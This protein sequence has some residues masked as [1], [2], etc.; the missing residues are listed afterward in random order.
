MFSSSQ[1]LELVSALMN[2][3]A[4]AVAQPQPSEPSRNAVSSTNSL[5]QATMSA[6]SSSSSS[7]PSSSSASSSCAHSTAALS[8]RPSTLPDIS[9]P[10][11]LPRSSLSSSSNAPAKEQS[12]QKSSSAAP[13]S[14][15]DPTSGTV[16]TDTAATVSTGTA[17]TA[18]KVPSTSVP[19]V[20]TSSVP[21]VY[22]YPHSGSLPRPLVHPVSSN[23]MQPLPISS[24]SP[25][26]SSVPSYPM[27]NPTAYPSNPALP[28]TLLP[29]I[30]TMPQPAPPSQLAPAVHMHPIRQHTSQMPLSQPLPHFYY[31]PSARPLS[32]TSVNADIH[33]PPMYYPVQPT[34]APSKLPTLS[35]NAT[36]LPQASTVQPQ[37]QDSTGQSDH[38]IKEQQQSQPVEDK[39]STSAPRPYSGADRTEALRRYKEKKSRRKSAAVSIRY[40]IRKQLADSRPRFRGRFYKPPHGRV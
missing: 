3:R 15:A 26:M 12:L 22:S 35:P 19:Y 13:V 10:P 2:M 5:P 23:A 7:S 25:S 17:T 4:C 27:F 20:P 30:H 29:T 8:S 40:Q 9:N 6:P 24:T 21:Q 16:A 1:D 31:L 18:S 39:S 32:P 37:M 33:C 14:S 34:H 28:S 36:S 38:N 11:S